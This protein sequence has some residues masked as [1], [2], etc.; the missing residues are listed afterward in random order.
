LYCIGH[1]LRKLSR[2]VFIAFYG[3]DLCLLKQQV[4]GVFRYFSRVLEVSRSEL[5]RCPGK[6]APWASGPFLRALR[7]LGGSKSPFGGLLGL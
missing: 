5:R 3:P 6:G 2:F 7:P 1:A 4:I